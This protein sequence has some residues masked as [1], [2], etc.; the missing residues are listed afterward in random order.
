MPLVMGISDTVAVIN[1]GK[2]IGLGSPEEVQ[3]MNDVRV[4]YL[5]SD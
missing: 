2:L 1:F 5:G 3:K 4:A